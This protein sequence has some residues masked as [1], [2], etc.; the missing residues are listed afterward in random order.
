[1]GLYMIIVSAFPFDAQLSRR[2]YGQTV[3]VGSAYI[4]KYSKY[5]DLCAQ[6]LEKCVG[7]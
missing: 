3:N 5:G 7:L 1:M 4:Q 2:R 6:L